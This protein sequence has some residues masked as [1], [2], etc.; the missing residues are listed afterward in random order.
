MNTQNIKTIYSKELKSYFNSPVAYI[1]MIVFMA[2]SGFLFTMSFFQINIASMREFFGS[3]FIQLVLFVVFIPAITMRSFSEEKK[4]GTLEL[5]LTKPITDIE[6]I[7]GKYLSALT[8]I[9][10]TLSP[11]ILYFIIIKMI[12]PIPFWPFLTSLLGYILM[13]AFFIGIGVFVSSLTEN[14]IIAF[15]VSVLICL[16]F[17]LFGKLLVVFPTSVVS[18]FEYLTTDYHLSNISRGVIDSRVLIY[19]FSMIFFTIFLTKVS[20]ESRKW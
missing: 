16:S 11:T 14:Q 7:L 19:Y 2:I 17:F 3:F 5:L 9:I 12:G 1:V 15:I 4:Q 13:S 20:L 8:L 10:I 6:L 18:F